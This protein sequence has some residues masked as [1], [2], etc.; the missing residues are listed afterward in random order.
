MICRLPGSELRS[1]CLGEGAPGRGKGRST[2]W[3]PDEGRRPVQRHGAGEGGGEGRAE[4]SSEGGGE[5]QRGVSWE[6]QCG[7]RP[8][9]RCG[10]SR[11]KESGGG[12]GEGTLHTGPGSMQPGLCRLLGGRRP[13]LCLP[14]RWWLWPVAFVPTG[15]SDCSACPGGRGHLP[16]SW[17]H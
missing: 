11:G 4:R 10:L 16:A 15:V 1:S 7:A 3:A 17:H 9:S 13:Y 8:Y 5:R 6:G 12:W 2:G 14:T